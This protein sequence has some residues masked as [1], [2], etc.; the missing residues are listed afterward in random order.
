MSFGALG[1]CAGRAVVP[2]PTEGH[3]PEPVA[4]TMTP[5]AMPAAEVTRAPSARALLQ[6]VADSALGTP[7]WRNARW[8][9][10]IVDATTGDTLYS[11][12]ADKLFMPASNQKLLTG[13]VALQVLGPEYRWRTP[14]LLRGTQRGNVFRGDLVVVGSGD[15]SVSDSLRGGDALSAFDPIVAALRARG[16]RRI[17][18]HVLA[19]GDAFPG[20]T[21][22]F[23]WEIDD[24]DTPSGAVVDELV[25]NEG[26]LR[27]VVRGG[28]S[29]KAPVTVSRT[30]TTRYPALRVEARTR[31]P[32][33]TGARIDVAYDSTAQTLVVTGTVAVGDSARVSTA[34][35]HPADAYR[36]A[37]LERLAA[38]GMRVDGGLTLP[39]RTPVARDP[40]KSRGADTLVVLES[41]PMRDVLPRLMKPS[42]N[43]IAELLFRTSGLVGTGSGHADSARAL[44]ARTL[45]QLGVAAEHVA[46]RDGSGLS[47]HDYVTPRAILQVLDAMRRAPWGSMFRLALPLA[48]VDG[49]IANRMKNTPAAGNASAK[50]GTLDKTRALSGYVTSADGRVVMFSMIANSYTVPTR[51]VDRV[52]DLLVATLAGM[53][54]GP[55]S[56]E[57]PR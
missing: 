54:F 33:D 45:T 51:E 10:L 56:A 5:V 34:Y 4:P 7:L 12:D 36:A 23:G 40:V 50:T 27:L 31:A 18:G 38:R 41:V 30:P 28:R 14:V 19:D 57:R 6:H 16:I 55:A 9:L 32:S 17:T 46:Y 44:A 25:F 24:Q 26:L 53:Q 35:R 43:Q 37:L 29:S 49:T 21:S 11:H 20:L 42:Q 47:R 1:A 2:A 13:A 39:L 52:Q 15:P 48:G 22:G 8:G 3:R